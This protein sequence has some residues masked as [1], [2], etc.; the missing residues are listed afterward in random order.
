MTRPKQDGSGTDAPDEPPKEATKLYF[1]SNKQTALLASG[2]IV[3]IGSFSK[4]VFPVSGL[5][6]GSKFLLAGAL[7]FLSASLAI[8]AYVMDWN[9]DIMVDIEEGKLSES[10]CRLRY[11]LKRT[12]KW[13]SRVFVL[14]LV[15]FALAALINLL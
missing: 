2:A 14:G 1:E 6:L 4:D 9:V 10:Y 11:K 5:D 3:L 8:A 15:C 13:S 7:I 12:A